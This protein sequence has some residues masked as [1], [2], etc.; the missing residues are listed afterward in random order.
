MQSIVTLIHF[1][2]LSFVKYIYRFRS[3]MQKQKLLLD[4][5]QVMKT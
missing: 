4:N 2:D 5:F 3:I 1:Y